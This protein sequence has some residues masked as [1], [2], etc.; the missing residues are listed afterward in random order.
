MQL[1]DCGWNSADSAALRPAWVW[2][3]TGAP[4]GR[5]TAASVIHNSSASGLPGGVFCSKLFEVLGQQDPGRL[6]PER[7]GSRGSRPWAH[8]ASRL[9]ALGER[10]HFGGRREL[11]GPDILE[12]EKVGEPQPIMDLVH[13]P[14]EVLLDLGPRY[15]VP[16]Q[17]DV[18]R[19]RRACA[20]SGSYRRDTENS[21]HGGQAASHVSSRPPTRGSIGASRRG[22]LNGPYARNARGI[23]FRPDCLPDV[24]ITDCPDSLQ[25]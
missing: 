8:S 25:P 13:D 20:E 11:H 12:P 23:S 17:V 9:D 24:D 10:Q 4:S 21:L 2:T 14:E 16:D 5:N 7:I 1:N 22:G 18:A 6:G 3:W 15:G 19:R